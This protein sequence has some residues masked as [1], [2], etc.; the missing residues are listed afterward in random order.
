MRTTLSFN[1]TLA[2]DPEMVWARV[3]S[4]DGISNEM[5]P[6]LQMSAAVAFVRRFFA[7]RQS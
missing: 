3:A 2:V 5:V 1:S 6:I 4:F 7:H